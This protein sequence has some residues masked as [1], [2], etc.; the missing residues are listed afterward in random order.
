MSRIIRLPEV[1]RIVGLSRS[2]VLRLESAQKFPAKLLLSQ[3][4]VGWREAEV[5][6]WIES[7]RPPT[8]GAEGRL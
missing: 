3:H 8:V 4:T 7:R 6:A 1:C 5:V 2:S